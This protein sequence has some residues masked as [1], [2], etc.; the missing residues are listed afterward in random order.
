MSKA[1][2]REIRILIQPVSGFCGI[3]AEQVDQYD[4]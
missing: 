3:I 1:F 4:E 2:K